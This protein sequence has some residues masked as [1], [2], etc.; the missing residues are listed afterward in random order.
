MIRVVVASLVSN[1]NI[2]PDPTVNITEY[3]DRF[4]VQL[5]RPLKVKLTP[6]VYSQLANSAGGEQQTRGAHSIPQKANGNDR[7]VE[8]RETSDQPNTVLVPD[9]LV[10]WASLPPMPNKNYLTVNKKA[11]QW[12]QE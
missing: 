2:S 8:T 10:S 4:S 9:L 3:W 5:K 12:F 6:I 1:F 11:D 7:L